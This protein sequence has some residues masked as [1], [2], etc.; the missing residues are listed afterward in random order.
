M[1]SKEQR[2]KNVIEQSLREVTYQDT[3]VCLDRDKFNYNVQQLV[4]AA[5]VRI[6]RPTRRARPT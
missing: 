4:D 2:I 5:Y 3:F 1:I 6:I